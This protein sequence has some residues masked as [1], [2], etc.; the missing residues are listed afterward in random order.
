[1]PGVPSR[2]LT[3]N[4]EFRTLP[5]FALSYGDNKT[6]ELADPALPVFSWPSSSTAFTVEN[7]CFLLFVQP[8]EEFLKTGIGQVAHD[9]IE[10]SAEFIMTPR[11]VNEILTGMARRDC[12]LP[13]FAPRHHVVLTRRHVSLTEHACFRHR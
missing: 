5:L 3:S 6:D 1:M 10:R 11:L 7:S 12:L 2:T 13:A 9:R 8:L 4:L